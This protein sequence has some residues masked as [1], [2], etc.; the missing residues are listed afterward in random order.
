MNDKFFDLKKEKQ[1][2]M[3]NAALKI[4][5]EN[6]YKRASTDDIVK[7]AGISKG[8]L[9]H[10][11]GSKIGL[12]EFLF[13]YSAKFLMLELSSL[14]SGQ[15]SDYFTICRQLIGT[16][17]QIMR[18]YPYLCLFLSRALQEKTAEFSVE[19][20]EKIDTY[21]EFEASIFKKV[22]QSNFNEHADYYKIK[23]LMDYTIQGTMEKEFKDGT[24]ET[25]KFY[26]EVISYLEMMRM[27]CYK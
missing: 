14:A 3:I 10:Y 13:D 18:N 19:L 17:V 16:K 22:K 7:E 6:G 15:E 23:E 20:Y 21:R 2:R 8:L 12:F 11:F 4:F 27:L 9:F 24:F 25:D 1:D 5:A 26:E